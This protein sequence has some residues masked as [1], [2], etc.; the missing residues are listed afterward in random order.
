MMFWNKQP[1]GLGG[2]LAALLVML[3]FCCTALPHN[4]AQNLPTSTAR[5]Q[6]NLPSPNPTSVEDIHS[7][8]PTPQTL[9]PCLIAENPLPGELSEAIE[10]FN[11]KPCEEQASHWR[12]SLGREKGQLIS[13]WVYAL[14]VPFPT[15]L[16]GL[17]RA[18]FLAFWQEGKSENFKVLGMSQETYA[19]LAAFLGKPKADVQVKPA[20]ML[21]EWAWQQANV[22]AILPFEELNP[23]WKVLSI[24]GQSPIHKDFSE[25][26]YLLA[27]HYQLLAPQMAKVDVPL[28]G[29]S[30]KIPSTNRDSKKLANL[31]M[32]GV[33]ALSRA[34]AFAMEKEGLAAP[35]A[36]IGP[37]LRTA[38]L[39]HVSNEVSFTEECPKPSDE[40]E[41]LL[42]C[43]KPI[44]ISVLDAIGTDLVELTGDHLLDYGSK[45]FLNT[46]ALYEAKGWQSYGGGASLALAQKPALFEVNGNKLA[47]LGCNGKH[48]GYQMAGPQQPGPLDCDIDWLVGE[49]G[50]L[51]NEGYLPIVTFQHME[52]SSWYPIERMQREFK[53]VAEAGAVIVSGSQAHR[54]QTMTFVGA[55]GMS[56]LHYGLGNLFF[57]Q[58]SMNDDYDKAFIDEHIFYDGRYI[59]TQLLTIQ[60]QDSL[61]PFWATKEVRAQMLNFAF[62]TSGMVPSPW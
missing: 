6:A 43:S 34:T 4:P 19:V 21:E 30:E 13:T 14:V 22:L 47:F 23:R 39:T 5:Q 10:R 31:I 35:A 9:A 8:L 24:E 1:K 33:T 20:N 62:W 26:R 18:A 53:E 27:V 46:L 56:F 25:N 41:S 12:I 32:T 61:T 3:C 50:R 42:L 11:G 28:A 2:I 36:V 15:V 51:K 58:Y 59:S 16:D 48:V 29:L 7:A 37:K 54:P 60:F 40:H 45:A 52:L 57:D 17:S 44:Y 38:D 49:V 55:E